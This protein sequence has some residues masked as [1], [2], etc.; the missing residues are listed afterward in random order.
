[1]RFKRKHTKKERLEL[2]PEELKELEKLEAE[3]HVE[4]MEEDKPAIREERVTRRETKQGRPAKQERSYD[5]PGDKNGK[6]EEQEEQQDA[7]GNR[8]SRRG[9]KDCGL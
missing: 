1:M 5:R 3:D 4:G 9:R 8:R 7:R 2:S 6:S